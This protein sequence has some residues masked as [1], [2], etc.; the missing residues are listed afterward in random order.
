[1]KDR[2]VEGLIRRHGALIGLVFAIAALVTINYA[3]AHRQTNTEGIT[4]RNSLAIEKG[5]TLLNNAIIRSSTSADSG[6]SQVLVNEILRNAIQHGRSWVVIEF[7]QASRKHPTV[8][9]VINCDQVA[10]DPSRIVALP[11]HPPRV[12]PPPHVLYK[13]TG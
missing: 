13:Q 8:I 10:K 1:M 9:P 11:I 2:N 3:L 5:C 4:A 7:K 6:P 12:K